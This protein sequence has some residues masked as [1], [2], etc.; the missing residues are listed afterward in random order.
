MLGTK[1][2]V[3]ID[4]SSVTK[5]NTLSILKRTG[6]MKYEMQQLLSECCGITRRGKLKVKKL[7]VVVLSSVRETCE[8]KALIRTSV[9]IKEASRNWDWRWNSLFAITEMLGW[10]FF[11]DILIKLTY[12]DE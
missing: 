5:I 9:L 10:I 6:L 11:N 4:S 3:C 8:V 7:P 12:T 1:I 2:C